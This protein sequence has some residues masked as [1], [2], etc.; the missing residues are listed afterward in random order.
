[1]PKTIK[2]Y[3][4]CVPTGETYTGIESAVITNGTEGILKITVANPERPL[5]PL[6]EY[7]V[8]TQPGAVATIP[9]GLLDRSGVA[10]TS[11]EIVVIVEGQTV[12]EMVIID[13]V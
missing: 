9:A 3:H 6:K 2:R 5:E 11:A 4:N 10:I 13:T 8:N 1:M 7:I 12:P